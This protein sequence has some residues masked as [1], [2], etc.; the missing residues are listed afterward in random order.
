M[1][2]YLQYLQYLQWRIT[3]VNFYIVN[4]KA[5]LMVIGIALLYRNEPFH[6][7]FACKWGYID[8]RSNNCLPNCWSF[9]YSPRKTHLSS[10]C[11]CIGNLLDDLWINNSL[12]SVGS[13]KVRGIVNIE[14]T[15]YIIKSVFNISDTSCAPL[16]DIFRNISLKKVASKYVFTNFVIRLKQ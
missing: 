9:L 5:T 11:F 10:C 4:V 14:K 2:E 1:D 3:C 16:Q 8:S 15:F 12:D 6:W 7:Y 13:Y